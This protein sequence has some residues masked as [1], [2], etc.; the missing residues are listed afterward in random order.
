MQKEIQFRTQP[1]L[2]RGGVKLTATAG[3]GQSKNVDC[4]AC[5]PHRAV[6]DFFSL[7][8]T[9][10]PGA[11]T[12]NIRD[13]IFKRLKEGT[14]SKMGD[15]SSMSE[16][17][18]VEMTGA[19]QGGPPVGANPGGQSSSAGQ[20]EEGPVATPKAPPKALVTKTSQSPP[21]PPRSPRVSSPRVSTAEVGNRWSSNLRTPRATI[22]EENTGD[23][24]S[25]EVDDLL[26]DRGGIDL[27][28]DT[29]ND[30]EGP[31]KAELQEYA[32]DVE[33]EPEEEAEVPAEGKGKAPDREAEVPQ[34]AAAAS[35]PS[36]ESPAAKRAASP[37]REER[38]AKP[39]SR[40]RRQVQP[41]RVCRSPT[42]PNART[43]TGICGIPQRPRR[44]LQ[45]RSLKG[46][47][48]IMWT[49]PT[50][51]TRGMPAEVRRH[52]EQ[53]SYLSSRG[54]RT[55]ARP[56]EHRSNRR[57]IVQHVLAREA[58]EP[59]I[60]AVIR[61]KAITRERVTTEEWKKASETAQ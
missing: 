8:R 36:V 20:R 21:N 41:A 45:P 59:F 43:M 16:S 11:V 40:M 23:G 27:P 33:M 25:A 1:T 58:G 30:G 2:Y 39:R 13:N 50:R 49:H 28:T 7:T 17:E 31:T 38:R 6:P 5:I 48:A 51:S 3:I 18:D 57:F 61:N 15:A 22:E 24:G 46:A 12:L 19:A 56:A 42:L 35:R 53:S 9:V 60:Y 32:G 10:W 44:E 52:Q 14:S 26:P 34:T 37:D 47:C 29:F 55:S 54:S 4:G